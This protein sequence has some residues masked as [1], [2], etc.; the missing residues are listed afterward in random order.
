MSLTDLRCLEKKSW[1]YMAWDVVPVRQD[2]C[3]A[4]EILCSF[5]SEDMLQTVPGNRA[6]K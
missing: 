2:Q 5:Y 1:D 3:Q 4:K 6:A